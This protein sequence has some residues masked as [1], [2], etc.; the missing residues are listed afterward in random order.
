MRFNVS[1]GGDNII[2]HI[3]DRVPNIFSADSDDFLIE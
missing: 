2:D 3:D 1:D